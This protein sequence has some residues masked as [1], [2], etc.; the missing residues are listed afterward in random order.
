MADLFWPGDERAG[1]LCSETSLLAGMV[2]VETAWLA[3]LVDLGIA[4]QAARSALVDAA[5]LDAAALDVPALAGAAE[6]GGN[7]VVPLLGLLRD[8][9]R[10][11][12]HETA[13]TWLHRG[14]TSQDVVDTALALC[15]DAALD[16]VAGRLRRTADALLALAAEHRS[17]VMVA[18]TLT[19]HAVPT[20]FGL[21]ATVWLDGVVD[22]YDDVRRARAGLAVQ[23]GGAAGTLSALEELAA[24]VGA[25]PAY[26]SATA[27]LAA[28]LGLPAAHPWHTSRGRLTRSADAL[29]SAV[30][31]CGRIASDVLVLARPEVGELGEPSG[32]GRGG[33]STMPQ[34][35]NPVLSVLLRRAALTTPGLVAT[36]RTSAALA[37]DERPDGAWHAEWATLRDLARRAATATD[38]AAELVAGLQVH[39]D[40][41]RRRAV[42]AVDAGLLAERA[43]VRRVAGA[44]HDGSSEDDLDPA[45]YLGAAGAIIDASTSRASAILAA[46]QGGTHP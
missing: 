44:E 17:S 38:Q 10:A 11:R 12:G 36:L 19:Q 3:T 21:K 26:P 16:A 5:A 34:K 35:Q 39:V 4:P 30:Q 14:L 46:P 8:D 20:T 31:A 37:D 7:P 1:D 22:A 9:L 29:A 23:V 41:M 2:R 33:S 45:S 32:E 27:H 15:L 24:A 13:A 43:A 6:A 40:V 25:P 18:R 28:A 42:D